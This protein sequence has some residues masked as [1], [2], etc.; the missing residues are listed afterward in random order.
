MMSNLSGLIR[1]RSRSAFQLQKSTILLCETLIIIKRGMNTRDF[2]Q[3]RIANAPDFQPVCIYFEDET[4]NEIFSALLEAR[5]IPTRILEK[6]QDIEGDTRIITE[7]RFFPLLDK[8]YHSKCLI[9]GNK[10]VLQ[11]INA[12][13]LSR[14]LTEEKI[15]DALSRFL[16]R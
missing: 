3:N 13:S 11:N 15:E 1:Q 12:L 14:P 4:I 2:D 8:C 6:I 16:G 9:V 5:G 10:D 7:P